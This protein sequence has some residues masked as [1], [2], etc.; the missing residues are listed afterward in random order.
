MCR[1]AGIIKSKT[2]NVDYDNVLTM[3]ASMKNGGPDGQGIFQDTN[4]VFGHN[5]L[6]ILDV[7]EDGHQPMHSNCQRMVI[8]YNGEIY[9]FAEIKVELLALGHLFKTKTDTEVII[10]AFLEWGV[11]SFSKLNGMFAFALYDKVN[12]CTYLVR[13]HFGIKPVYYSFVNKAIT[14]S[15]E[16]RAFKEIGYEVDSGKKWQALYLAFGY[17][18]NPITY[19]KDVYMLPKGTYLKIDEKTTNGLLKPIKFNFSPL[20]R[21][22]DTFRNELSNAV[23]RQLVSDVE[24]GAFFSGGI[25]SSVLSILASTLE[26]RN[27]RTFSIDFEQENYSEE[28]YRDILS[29]KFKLNNTKNVANAEKFKLICDDFLKSMDQPSVDGLNVYFVS[30]LCAQNKLKVALSG[31]GADELLGGYDSLNRIK[32]ISFIQ[33]ALPLL[34][35]IKIFLPKNKIVNRSEYLGLNNLIGDHLF[36]RGLFSL[37]EISHILNIPKVT[38]ASWFNEFTQSNSIQKTPKEFGQA[39]LALE[40]VY[41]ESQLLKDSDIFGMHHSLEIRVPFL[42]LEFN[43]Y[44]NNLSTKKRFDKK[45]KKKILISAFQNELPSDLTN[46]KKMGFSL[47]I[48]LWLEKLNFENLF[49][50]PSLRQSFHNKRFSEYQKWSLFVLDYKLNGGILK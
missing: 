50:D 16:T 22:F 42:D 3:L 7:S 23:G 49:K 48:G 21:D 47:P 29:K 13:D 27:F 14:F 38:I 36:L 12:G 8:T 18:P 10:N 11:E 5:R 2:S 45:Q 43:H 6:S 46:R 33:F 39:Y 32:Y 41:L 4:I 28:F 19:L 40:D 1:I 34:R 9:N 37:D 24:V 31:L 17:I 44:L 30:H 25:D 20:K 35:I 15:S 26:K